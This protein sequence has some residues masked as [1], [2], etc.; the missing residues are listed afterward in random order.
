M[1]VR[2]I[3]IIGFCMLQGFANSQEQGFLKQLPEDERSTIEA[4]ALY[5]EKERMAILEITAHPEILVRMQNMRRKTEVQLQDLLVPLPEEDQKRL[6]NLFRYPELMGEMCEDNQ[7]MS[8]QQISELL[9]AYPQKLWEDARIV[10]RQYFDEFSAANELFRKSEQSF[11]TIISG[12]SPSLQDAYQQLIQLPEII[13]I[14]AENMNMTVLLGDVYRKNPEELKDELDAL[15]LVVAEQ[16]A[17]ELNDWKQNLEKDPDAKREYER[18]SQEFAQEQGYDQSDYVESTAERNTTDIYVHHVWRPYP[19]WFGW[20]WW[21]TYEYWYPY[22]WW[23]HSGYYYGPGNT[24]VFIGLPSN[25]FVYWHFN[26]YTHFYHYPHFTNHIITHYHGHRKS[27]TSV[28]TVVRNWEAETRSELPMTMVSNTAGRVEQIKE[29]GRFQMEHEAAVRQ[30]NGN[31][32]TKAEYLEQNANR[33][34]TL[35]PAEKAKPQQTYSRPRGST[36]E[37]R[38][39]V[40]PQRTVPGEKP[41][42]RERP[43]HQE[44]NKATNHHQNTWEKTTPR[45]SRKIPSKAAPQ[46]TTPVKR[47][48]P[49]RPVSPKQVPSRKMPTKASPARKATQSKPQ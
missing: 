26:R 5:P 38:Q 25:Y 48:E 31:A 27:N 9:E 1:I 45:P 44:I 41:V 36:E 33:Y 10:N 14:L 16:K 12:Y 6:F 43:N 46:K 42:E 22:P 18:A 3:F 21:Y 40:K 20:P 34:P 4:I 47:V 24:M 39:E 37:N 28:A 49:K 11:E 15:N 7:R 8:E 17:Q 32:L 35:K 19:Y 13:N 2:T 23:Y 29:Y 30:A